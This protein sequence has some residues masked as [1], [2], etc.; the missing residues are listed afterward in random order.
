M[1]KKILRFNFIG[2]EYNYALVYNDSKN[3]Y[4]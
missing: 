3:E 4:I 2:Y 1:V